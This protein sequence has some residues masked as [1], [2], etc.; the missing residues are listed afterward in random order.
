MVEADPV[1]P[2][3]IVSIDTRVLEL[4]LT[5]P[6]GISGGSQEKA[7][8]VLVGVTLAD[9]TRGTGE[10]APLPAYNGERVENALAAVD[11]ARALLVGANAAAWR[12]R[13]LELRAPTA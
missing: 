11:A 7:A 10:A 1:S 6:F 3:S 2:T 12:Q 9:G 5:E 13:A 8:I 4:E